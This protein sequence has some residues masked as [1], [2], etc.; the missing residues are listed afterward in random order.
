MTRPE[1]FIAVL[2]L[3]YFAAIFTIVEVAVL[4]QT[5]QITRK[6]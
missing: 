5:A 6:T 2:V 4:L 3:L 1:D